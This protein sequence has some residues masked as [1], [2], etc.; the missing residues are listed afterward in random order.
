M[1]K[2]NKYIGTSSCHVVYFLQVNIRKNTEIK[3]QN[4][5]QIKWI[6]ASLE[7]SDSESDVVNAYPKVV[8]P[9]EVQLFEKSNFH[10]LNRQG[11]GS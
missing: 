4:H 7:K 11:E 3:S 9:K 10:H 2:P 6:E 1:W 5:F 8:Y